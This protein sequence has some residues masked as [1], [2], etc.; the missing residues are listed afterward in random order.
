MILGP[1]GA[2]KSTLLSI[3]ATLDQPS[4]GDVR[5]GELDHATMCRIGRGSIG[6]A[7]HQSLLYEELTGMENLTFYARL[8]RLDDPGGTAGRLVDRLGLSD[9][10]QRAVRTYSRGMKQRLSVARALL[11]QP[12]IL[13]LDEPLSGLDREGVARVSEVLVE[14]KEGGTLVAFSSHIFDLPA[15]VI[16]QA[17][18]LRRGKL[19]AGGPVD[20]N[21]G[22]FYDEAMGGG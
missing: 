12:D 19:I 22:R 7:S 21:V 13:L 3:L 9:A 11:N 20:G 6:W 1:N 15:G 17:F 8:Y 4:K 5:Y 18:V 10:G 16:D 2:G 14:A